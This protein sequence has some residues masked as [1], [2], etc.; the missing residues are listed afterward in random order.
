MTAHDGVSA[1]GAQF[2][3]RIFSGIIWFTIG[4]LMFLVLAFVMWWFIIYKKKFNIKVKINSE[5]AGDRNQIIFDQAAIL[6]DRKDGTK[7]FRLW[8]TKIDLPAPKFNVLQSTSKGDY[9]ELYR[10]SEN[11]IYFLTPSIID[12]TKVIKADGKIYLIAAQTNR[13]IDPDM[14]FWAAR[15][16]VENKSLFDQDSLIMKLLPYLPAIMGGM[17]TIFVL[18]I[19][20]DNLPQIL[21]QLSELVKEMR[22]LQGASITRG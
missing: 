2:V 15:R 3:E 19:L 21:T 22:S 17:I 4:T 8:D 18:Y 10:T 13:Q 16:M 12:K 20:L 5:R 7:Y 6:R 11:T 1:I 9:I 14:D